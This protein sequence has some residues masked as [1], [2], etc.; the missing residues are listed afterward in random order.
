MA[1]EEHLV[2]LFF[3][4]MEQGRLAELLPA[5]RA[6]V[7]QNASRPWA[8]AIRAALGFACTESGDLDG[9]REQ[10]NI[11]IAGD[12]GGIPFDESWL[13]AMTFLAEI[14]ARLGSE[15]CAALYRLLA[16][17]PDRNIL[18]YPGVCLG[19][20]SRPLGLLASALHRWDEAER[21][22]AGALAM[23]SKMGA[24]PWVARTQFNYAQMLLARGEPGDREKARSLL[25][26]ALGAAR[27]MGMVK[28][29]S[30]CE[31]LLPTVGHA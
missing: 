11:L 2:Q 12:C 20:S 24:R 1:A 4:Y 31:A 10:L 5:Q 19:S 30:D 18:V 17:Y 28:V 7:E 29:A 14:A 15:H 9:A 26:E 25:Q 3:L 13:V 21:H 6:F 27:Q 16:P 8:A 22:F 23:N